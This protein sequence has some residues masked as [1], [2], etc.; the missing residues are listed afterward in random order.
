MLQVI[1]NRFHKSQT[2][3]SWDYLQL[4]SYSTTNVLH[5]SKMG[6]GVIIGLIDTGTV[7][8]L[9]VNMCALVVCKSYLS[10]N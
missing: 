10:P 7:P 3:R 9:S 4:S 5:K 8:L 2:T 1:P 6:N